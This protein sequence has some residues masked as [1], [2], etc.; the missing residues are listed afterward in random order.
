[1]VMPTQITAERRKQLSEKHGIDKDY[2][3]Q[4]LTGRRDLNPAQARRLETETQGELTRKMLCQKT[5]AGIWPELA[6][7]WDGVER[8]TRVRRQVDRNLIAA[9]AKPNPA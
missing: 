2:L 9:Q 4:C 7:P 1:M 5:Y 8:R 6:Q 3:Y